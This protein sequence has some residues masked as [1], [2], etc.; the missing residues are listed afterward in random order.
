LKGKIQA[1][2]K[3]T[4]DV[5]SDDYPTGV[6]TIEEIVEYE[7]NNDCFE[8]T[9]IDKFRE[10]NGHYFMVEPLYEPKPK[11]KPDDSIPFG[12]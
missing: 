10:E 11:P 7:R 12:Y 8:E 6:N 1:T 2:I 5:N 4:F 3:V 9:V